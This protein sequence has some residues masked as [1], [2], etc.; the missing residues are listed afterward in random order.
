MLSE[1]LS[2][3][4]TRLLILILAVGVIVRAGAAIYLGNQVEPVS[5]AADQVSYH[6]LALRVLDGHGFTFGE[7]WWPATPAGAPTAHWSYL[8]TLYLVAVYWLF[9]PNPLVARLIQAGIV[10]LLQPY[11]ALLLGRRVFGNAVGWVA[12]A[13]TAVYGY[14]IFYA[15]TLMTEPFYITAIL[16]S[17]YLSIRLVD[18][19]KTN[20][21]DRTSTRLALSLGVTLA[22]AILLRQLIML[23][24]PFLFAWILWA[25]RPWANSQP[26]RK[27][28]L[29]GLIILAAIVPITIFNYSRFDRFVLLNTNA[30][31]AFFWGNH[32]IYGSSFIPILPDYQSL[33]P[34]ELLTLDEAALDFGLAPTRAPVCPGRSGAVC[35]AFAEPDPSLLHLLADWRFKPGQQYC[36]H[37][38]FRAALAFYALRPGPR[39]AFSN[40]RD[41][42]RSEISAAPPDRVRRDIYGSPCVDLD[43]DPLSPPGRCGHAGFC[44][45]RDLRY[46]R[47][48]CPGAQQGPPPGGS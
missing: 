21:P 33:L 44:R 23:L 39:M 9:G 19:L 40:L 35:Q 41:P 32:P 18:V 47:A 31:F 13:L 36:P 37:A 27:L 30:G 25:S 43:P 22:A 26:I 17:L 48:V 38:E 14:F 5:G 28:V 29:A 45:S 10:G 6:N 34:R 16:G 42:T 24:V 8:Y 15:G 4:K 7:D 3:N 20:P 1:K 2:Q 46:R 11:L 12:A